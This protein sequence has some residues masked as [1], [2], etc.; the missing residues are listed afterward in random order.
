MSIEFKVN[1]TQAIKQRF[2]V[3]G[4]KCPSV[5]AAAV[6][7]RCELIKRDSMENTPVLYN[8]LRPSHEV[9]LP[10]LSDGLIECAVFVGGQAKEYAIPV[11]E[12]TWI[13]HTSQVKGPGYKYLETALN[14]A[15]PTF[16][17]DVAKLIWLDRIFK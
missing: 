13:K 1:G 4:Q 14:D 7:E 17:A 6:Y 11:H 10:R 9:S 15:K 8:V 12:M 2:I 16:A 3:A 5:V